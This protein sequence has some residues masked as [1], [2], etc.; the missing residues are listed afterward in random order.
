MRPS[1]QPFIRGILF[2]REEA[3]KNFHVPLPDD[4]YRSLRA[5]AERTQVPATTLVREAI[6]LWLREQ[7]R[8]ARHVAISDY[9]EEMAG[10]ELDLDSAFE[11]AGVRYLLKRGA[12]RR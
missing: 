6:D 11:E 3:M 10:T 5:E 1:N 7:A 12:K 9:A 8:K 2:P 4:T